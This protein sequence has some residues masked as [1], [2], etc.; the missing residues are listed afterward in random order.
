MFALG[1]IDFSFLTWRSQSARG[2][3][4]SIN[5]HLKKDFFL[6]TAG[7]LVLAKRVIEFLCIL[8]NKKR[9]RARPHL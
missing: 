7:G 1:L 3:W 6:A 5:S 8:V 4:K 9:P 2:G